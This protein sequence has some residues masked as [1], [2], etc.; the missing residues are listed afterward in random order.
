MKRFIILLAACLGF[1]AQAQNNY[2][3]SLSGV[4]WVKIESKSDII[5]QT[6]DKNEIMIKGS[7]STKTVERAKGLKLVG[8][9]GSDNT[10][11]GFY[12]VQDGN[13]L[14]VKNLRKAE[15]AHIFLPANQK[16]AVKSTWNGDIE[17]DGFTGEIEA[18]AKLNGSI[19]IRNANGPVTANALNGNIDVIFDTV[20]QSSPISIYTTNG[21]VDVTLPGSTPADLSISA[22]NGDIY[23]N[24]DLKPVDKDGMK[25]ISSRRVKSTINNGGVDISLKSTNGNIYLRKQ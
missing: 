12:V 22:T 25:S 9:G 17:I 7:N 14:I 24:F 21:E 20:K 19:D 1:S 15:N 11:I 5:V 8:E 4:E 6:Y 18:D 10:N 2:T 23:S 3:K 13:T 16:I